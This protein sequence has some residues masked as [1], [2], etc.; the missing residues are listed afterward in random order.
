MDLASGIFT[1]PRTGIYF[2][3]FTGLADF[4]VSSSAVYLKV[5]LHFIGHTL[6]GINSIKGTQMIESVYCDL[7]KIPGDAGKAI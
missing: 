5:W 1:A 2:F 3:S 6:N 4:P 7:T